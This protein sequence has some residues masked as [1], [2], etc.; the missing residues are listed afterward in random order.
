MKKEIMSPERL[1]A[2]LAIPDLTDPQNGIH[3]INII[4]GK[5]RQALEK[6][7][8]GVIVEEVR[9]IPEVSSRENFDDLLFSVDNTG[10]SS[11]YTRYV[12]ED[13][14]LR[15]HTSSAV[16]KLLK[17]V[18]R[19]SVSDTIITLP[20][21]CY[22]RDVVD[23]THCSEPHQMDVWRIKRGAPHFGRS[24][25][26]Q[27]VETILDCT[28]PGYDYRANE[29]EHPYT[30]NGL[31]VEIFVNGSW[32]EVLECGETHPT[33]LKNAGLDPEVY[34]GLALGMGLDRLVM[35]IKG[36]DDIRVLRSDDP[37]IRRQMT[38][39]EKFVIV[40]NQPTTKRVLS[41]STSVEK[42]E[43]D[44]CEEIRDELGTDAVFIE[45][46]EYSEIPYEQ[47][48]EKAV[49]NLGI[50]PNQKNVVATLSF[51]SLEGSL[52][53]TKVNEWMQRLY[54]KLNKGDRGY[55]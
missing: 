30:K 23:K 12:T 55:M 3:A 18:P 5:I 33:I 13:T 50:H 45:K 2:S 31:E 6:S 40:S 22:R 15:T 46:I 29:V 16:P 20:G 48:P 51:R 8:A 34:S 37:R 49:T 9:S 14:V 1:K 43:E 35:I 21:M 24:D 52:L 42:T 44:I 25:L 7:Y 27:L 10:R 19:G 39:L 36:I 53:R 28:V 38:N 47:L 32:L 26:I 41:Y 11:R 17:K 54:P 4:V